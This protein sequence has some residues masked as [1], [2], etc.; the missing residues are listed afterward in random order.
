MLLNINQINLC[1]KKDGIGDPVIFLHGWGV[2]K[3][4]FD[5]V[6]DHVKDDFCC[7][8]IDLPGF[9]ESTINEALSLD[10][11]TNI[12]RTF[13]LK[14]EIDN[15]I[16]IGHSFGGRIAINY[17]SLYDVKKLV[18]VNSAGVRKFNLNTY[19]KIKLFKICRKL[20]I[21]NNFGSTDYKNSNDLL[22]GTMNKIVP[23]DLQDRMKLINSETLI[24]WGELDKV[25]P[26]SDA[27]IMKKLITNA[28][29]IIIPK[30]K[31]FP[32]IDKYRY[33]TLM[34]SSFL[35]SDNK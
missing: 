34:L 26:L 9:G 6:V 7:Y 30:S 3:E 18:L 19:L 20:K 17:A 22:K 32:Y 15:P 28:T 24:L 5:K 27:R 1:Y 29:L 12:L 11:Y 2:T 13:I 14:E 23:I 8:Q 33:F 35:V 25:T 31:H 10:D 16:I 4:T 21:K